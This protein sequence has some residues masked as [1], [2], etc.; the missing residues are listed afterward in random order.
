MVVFQSLTRENEEMTYMILRLVRE[1]GV[2]NLKEN[3]NKNMS[4]PYRLALV[5]LVA[6]ATKVMKFL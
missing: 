6:A 2:N 1:W 4:E 3:K 5:E